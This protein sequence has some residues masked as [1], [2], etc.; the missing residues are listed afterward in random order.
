M[1]DLQR[2]ELRPGMILGANVYNFRGQLLITQGT[3]LTDYI[4]AKLE[5]YGIRHVK[6]KDGE[7]SEVEKKL[8]EATKRIRDSKEFKTFQVHYDSGVDVF[9]DSLN[10]IVEKNAEVDVDQMYDDMQRL[11]A[12]GTGLNLFDMIQNLRQYDDSTYAHAVNVAMICNILAGWLDFS[13]ED[14]KTATMCGLLHDIGKVKIPSSIIKK[15]GKLTEEE[16]EVIKRHTIEG[17]QILREKKMDRSICNAAL[18]HHEKCD[19]S[20]YPFGLQAEQIDRYGKLVA[21]ADIYDAMTSDRV[22]RSALSPFEVIQLFEDEGLYRY[23]ARYIM[24][25]LQR[26][27]DTY[28]NERVRLNDGREGQ[29]VYINRQQIARPTVQCGD[30]LVD[31]VKEKDLKIEQML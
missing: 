20:G 26:V 18:M 17:Y 10:D 14:I 29:I 31:L 6:V 2:E 12:G 28:L 16:F 25:F 8:S 15:P 7:L 22:Y 27:A 24:T 9:R 23:D 30:T 3:V 21:V 4:I 19:G 5:Y 13:A 11:I 1:K